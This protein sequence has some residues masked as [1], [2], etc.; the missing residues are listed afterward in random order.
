MAV[1]RNFPRMRGLH[2]VHLIVFVSIAD[3]RKEGEQY[4]GHTDILRSAV[5]RHE[6][7]LAT[8]RADACSRACR[9][10]TNSELT[11]QFTVEYYF[12]EN[13][14]LT[15]RAYH[16]SKELDQKD[17]TPPGES[18]LIGQC[19][20]LLSDLVSSPTRTA[21][22]LEWERNRHIACLIRQPDVT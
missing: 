22:Y 12:E 8:K 3:S 4:I 6:G 5:N 15:L 16:S 1:I 20:M 14:I 7:T 9:D 21:R 2:H 17:A 10:V 13:Q 18:D 19:Q 11:P